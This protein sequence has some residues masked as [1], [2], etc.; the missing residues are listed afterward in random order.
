MVNP[1]NSPEDQ[2]IE[3]ITHQVRGQPAD[4]QLQVAHQPVLRRIISGTRKILSHTRQK[5][6]SWN[7]DKGEQSYAPHIDI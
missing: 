1:W 7:K 3:E 6:T 2:D 4:G 5:L